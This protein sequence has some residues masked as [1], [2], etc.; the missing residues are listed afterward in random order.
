MVLEQMFRADVETK[1]AKHVGISEYDDD[2]EEHTDWEEIERIASG[3]HYDYYERLSTWVIDK[4]G[5]ELD[6]Y[7]ADLLAADA[8][9]IA[10]NWAQNYM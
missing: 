2:F 5:K 1:V 9:Q 7:H 8:I 3:G 4:Y 6:A 10:I